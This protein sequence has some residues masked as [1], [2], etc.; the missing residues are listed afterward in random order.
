MLRFARLSLLAF[1][2]SSC[3]ASSSLA[4]ATGRHVALKGTLS[5]RGEGAR[6]LGTTRQSIEEQQRR[7]L[8]PVFESWHLGS[9]NEGALS[10]SVAADLILMPY[11]ACLQVDFA[12]EL[13]Y[14]HP[15][16]VEGI[17]SNDPSV[18]GT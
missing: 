4:T 16:G 11:T 10:N 17:P 2:L 12:E 7:Q 14:L 13:L 5:S 1:P 9:H 15:Q 6:L 18:E 3:L 8:R